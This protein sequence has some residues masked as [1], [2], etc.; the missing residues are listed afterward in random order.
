[1]R[2]L[3]LP[4]SHTASR[5]GDRLVAWSEAR[6]LRPFCIAGAGE[7][8]DAPVRRI[9]AGE[10]EELPL[11]DALADA[12]PGDVAFFAFVPLGPGE[13]GDP[14]F[15][16]WLERFLAWVKEDVV[17]V[18]EDNL[19]ACGLAVAPAAAD[20]P[21]P[22]DFFRAR[23][24]NFLVAAEDR[25]RP[26]AVSQLQAGNGADPERHLRHAAHAAASLGALWDT[27]GKRRPDVLFQ[28]EDRRGPLLVEV[29]VARSFSRVVEL[30]H[31]ADHVAARVFEPRG[32]WPRPGTGFEHPE[33]AGRLTGAVARRFLERHAAV[34]EGA[35]FEPVRE[36][37]LEKLSLGQ[38][39][40]VLIG[41]IWDFLRRRPFELIEDAVASVHD[42]AARRIERLSAA[43]GPVKVRRWDERDDEERDLESL[44]ELLDED[45][46]VTEDGPV[47][48]TWTE[49]RQTV[50]GL[51]DG[52]DLPEG[53]GA[54][55]QGRG[56]R[57]VVVP[58][59]LCL[60]ADPQGEREPDFEP[61]LQSLRESVQAAQEAAEARAAALSVSEKAPD[62][63]EEDEAEQEPRS[64]ERGRHWL[65]SLMR[66]VVGYWLVSVV[67]AAAMLV[68]L[69]VVSALVAIVVIGVLWLLAMA[70]LARNALRLPRL[71]ED[72]VAVRE[73]AELNRMLE[74]AQAQ[75]DARRLGRRLQELDDWTSILTELIHR[76]WVREPFEQVELVPSVDTATLPTACAVG[77]ARG[78]EEILERT[79]ARARAKTFRPGWLSAVYRAVADPAMEEFN[80]AH[81]LPGPPPDPAADVSANEDSPRGT[82][83]AAM[84]LGQGRRRRDNP[85]AEDLLAAIDATFLDDLAPAV[86]PLSTGF[87]PLGPTATWIE[88]P[89]GWAAVAGA[90]STGVV[91]LRGGAATAAMIAPGVALTAAPAVDGVLGVTTADGATLAV[92]EAVVP[93]GSALGVLHLGDGDG[94]AVCPGPPPTPPRRG[95]PVVAVE[96]GP[97]GA[98]GR[99]GYVVADGERPVAVYN[100]GP[101]A[102]GAAV[103]DL[104]GQLVAIQGEREE[105]LRVPDIEELLARAAETA[106]GNSAGPAVEPVSASAF[107]AAIAEENG[108]QVLRSGYWLGHTEDNSIELA[109]PSGIL[110][111]DL[112][113]P[114]SDLV[115]GAAYM[116]PLRVMVHRIELTGP[117]EPDR[118]AACAR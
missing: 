68:L 5:L 19:L 99:W 14:A 79:G 20:Q 92:E 87:T 60:A 82:L 62:E 74:R 11:G 45:T 108:A 8:V 3:L 110:K 73:L 66:R 37:P 72:P 115:G 78:D 47:A 76:P 91:A 90:G 34:L 118:L 51:I 101:P 109:F 83:L 4:D 103:F 43:T 88:A 22:R 50:L 89:P 114:V 23:W 17:D 2:V 29:R 58:D 39:L 24:M 65:V 10:T 18:D 80:L 7:R 104:S 16:D 21:V 59:P 85:M 71:P 55:T 27:P 81:G 26:G 12:P 112:L 64:G 102:T 67:A 113:G 111:E 25:A 75:G 31:L 35:R 40:L 96:Q 30:G 42:Q 57:R 61:M 52:S 6:L 32:G 84:R 70:R 53:V 48:R 105:L 9:D 100:G 86:V 1:M 97:E 38:A 54:P 41:Q 56:D 28:M 33:D 94:V 15:A 107:L 36:E 93:A 63:G 69:P 49:L 44:G 46:V 98:G 95:E 13:T 77:A 117:V 106:V 116:Q